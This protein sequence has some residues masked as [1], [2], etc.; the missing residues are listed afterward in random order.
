MLNLGLGIKVK[1]LGGGVP[2][3]PPRDPDTTAFM[4]ATGIPDDST[5]YYTGTPQEITGTGLWTAIDT[6][7]LDLKDASLWSDLQA[8]YPFVGGTA[9]THKWN[10]KNPLD[11]D[12]AFR[13][14]WGGGIT[15][16]R[17]GV[18][19]NGTNAYGN[20]HIVPSTDINGD[21]SFGFK[22]G[23]NA[24]SLAVIGS[25]LNLS[26]GEYMYVYPRYSNAALF[27]QYEDVNISSAS[28][29]NTD[30]TGFYR[31]NQLGT[32]YKALKDNT[33]K[34]SRTATGVYPNIPI[35]LFCLNTDNVSFADFGVF[36]ATS[37]DFFTKGLSSVE[38]TDLNT[39]KNDFE[40]ALAR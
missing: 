23:N 27:T 29:S 11:T 21:S 32:A 7:V 39:I 28:Y 5:V 34:T 22:I 1:K 13:L 40:T 14:T 10:L 38:M 6:L 19:G 26:N 33:L 18:T 15:H 20:T 12:A 16:D 24:D 3:P 37:F 9:S 35:A 4:N 8:F 17:L 36:N 30:S 25:I 2:P 31:F